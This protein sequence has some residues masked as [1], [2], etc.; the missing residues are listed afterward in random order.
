MTAAQNRAARASELTKCEHR[1]RSFLLRAFAVAKREGR[2]YV[3]PSIDTIAGAC[4]CHRSTVKRAK[5]TFRRLGLFAFQDRYRVHGDRAWRLPD[6]IYLTAR[7]AFMRPVPRVAHAS[8]PS[9]RERFTVA[10]A[11]ALRPFAPPRSP[12]PVPAQERFIFEPASTSH[13]TNERPALAVD[14]SKSSD[15]IAGFYKRRAD[16]LKTAG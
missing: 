14:R 13:L 15:A 3:M 16:R 1:I 7:E 10:V 5:A 9:R 2:S 12:I 4:G 6:V 8:G 11:A